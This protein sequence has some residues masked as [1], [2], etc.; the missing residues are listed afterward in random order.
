M[1]KIILIL[2]FG[3]SILAGNTFPD[4]IERGTITSLIQGDV[5]CYLTLRNDQGRYFEEM[6][7]FDICLQKNLLIGKEV[8]LHYTTANVLADE[9]EGDPECQKSQQVILVESVEII[10]EANPSFCTPDE[11][12][13]FECSKDKQL[14]SV[15]L[16][17]TSI[18]QLRFGSTGSPKPL[19]QVI[20]SIGFQNLSGSTEAFSGGGAAWLKFHTPSA[21]HVVYTGIGKWGPNGS[22]V[23]KQ[24]WVVEGKGS[25]KKALAC[26][27]PATSLL[28]P[29][30]FGKYN[31]QANDQEFDLP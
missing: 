8:R 3:L 18:L 20:T 6:G 23:E 17:S 2:L 14:I 21:T 10:S 9:C 19:K 29:D 25:M 5:A 31:I 11:E 22:I 12:T 28:G 4:K 24:G 1:N 26:S 30:W 7:D 15:C 13:V 27:S 16:D